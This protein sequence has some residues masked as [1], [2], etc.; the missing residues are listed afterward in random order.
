[1]KTKL[2]F[3]TICA[4]VIAIH[5][6]NYLWKKRSL[7]QQ[8]PDYSYMPIITPVDSSRVVIL[9]DSWVF[10]DKLTDPIMETLNIYTES[11]GYPGYT[12]RDLVSKLDSILITPPLA[13]IIV[14]GV[15]DHAQQ[16]GADFYS[17]HAELLRSMCKDKGTIPIL[18]ELPRYYPDDLELSLNSWIIIN[19]QGIIHGT[20]QT[21]EQ[22]RE[23]I[24]PEVYALDLHQTFYRDAA[25]LNDIGQRQYGYYLANQV[26]NYL[27]NYMYLANGAPW[28]VKD[29]IIFNEEFPKGAYTGYGD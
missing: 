6:N 21:I 18:V 17:Y 24:I 29:M 19:A 9:G 5:A 11:K 12:T 2:I 4:I 28:E 3:L 14:A 10:N 25:H 7:F 15:N 1:M 16:L 26:K 8:K 23:Q 20:N 22:Y 27:D 13:V